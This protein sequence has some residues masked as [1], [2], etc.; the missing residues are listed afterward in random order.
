MFTLGTISRLLG[1]MLPISCS[2]ENDLQGFHHLIVV[3][4]EEGGVMKHSIAREAYSLPIEEKTT[5][6]VSREFLITKHI[7]VLPECK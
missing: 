5:L 2:E 6:R 7:V 3:V 1:G 4:P